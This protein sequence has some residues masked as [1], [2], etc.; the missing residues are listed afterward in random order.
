MTASDPQGFEVVISGDL[1]G[2]PFTCGRSCDLHLSE[3]V[4]IANY[5]VT[6]VR[7]RTA[8]GSS[9]WRRDGTPLILAVI[10]PPIDGQNG[11]H[12]SGVDVSANA[13]DVVPRLDSV[14]GS[15]DDGVIWNSLPLHL[16]DG[17]HPVL[18]RARDIAGNA[19]LETK[20]I[21]VDTVPPVSLFTSHSN[22]EV[23]HGN[24]RLTG[25]RR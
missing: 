20:V 1:N 16:V 6:S 22:G 17:I 9:A 11:W 3:G 15:M 24:V 7:G 25:R 13:F 18:V 2:V 12:V 14:C 23:V 19:A 21:R 4:G 8:S 10:V 5:R